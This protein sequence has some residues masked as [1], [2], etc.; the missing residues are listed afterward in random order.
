MINMLHLALFLIGA[1]LYDVHAFSANLRRKRLNNKERP[2]VSVLVP[3][4]NEE[5]VIERSLE[6]IWKNTYEN[7]EIIVISDGSTDNTD[8]VVQRF[9]TNH[10]RSYR[11]SSIKIN[12]TKYSLKR[13]WK[14]GKVPIYR[15]IK[16]VR[17]RNN[18]KGAALNRALRYHT[19]GELVM[20]LDA[21]SLL[22]KQAI[23]NVIKYFDDPTVAGVAAN[24]RII[25]K[26][27][28]LGILQ[29]FEH[30]ISYR[31]K[32]FFTVANCE[33][34]IGGVA[35]TYR[36]SILD[37]VGN[38]DTDTVTED[39]GLSFKVAA[40][41]NRQNRLIYAVDVA[42]MTE[43]VGDLRTLIRQR[44]RWK[45]GSLQ[46]LFKYRQLFFAS[47]QQYTKALTWYRVPMAFLGE[48]LLLLEPITLLYIVYISIHFL[49]LSLVL[50]AYM[51]I[52]LYLLMIIWPDEHL[53]FLGKMR[54][55]IYI[56]ILYFVFY[57]M[58]AVQVISILR[59][60]K[61]K[62]TITGLSAGHTNWVSP[63]RA[64]GTATFS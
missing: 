63:E 36:R 53:T 58:N 22:H 16:L 45:M 57:I 6:S 41:G 19:R 47:D 29:R 15:K 3:A 39:I 20:A 18:G 4:F 28:I 44:Y 34:I 1:N 8:A 17:Q 25:E 24:V 56:P 38:Y 10:A 7:L 52:C 13:V 46:N 26:N 61:N 31:S 64:G 12:R 23:T 5:I 27:R 21:D 62:Q 48:I 2:L 43:G 42:A 60:I 11:G 59:C 37:K 35:S 32:K 14:R 30:M 40:L 49:T 51:T 55:S 33:L 54:A 9:M 50:G